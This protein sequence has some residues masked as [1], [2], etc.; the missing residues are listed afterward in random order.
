[1]AR[2]LGGF[3]GDSLTY[4]IGAE[5]STYD[6]D[7]DTSSYTGN[8]ANDCQGAWWYIYCM[9]SNLNGLYNKTGQYGINWYPWRPYT[10]SLMKTE[11]K[12]RPA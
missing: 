5:F 12:M 10:Y 1:M 9:T 8:C 2:V 11:M 7:H 3:A 4:H 6:A